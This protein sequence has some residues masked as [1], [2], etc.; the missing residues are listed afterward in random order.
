MNVRI[1]QRLQGGPWWI[2][3]ERKDGKYV[4]QSLNTKDYSEAEKKG[5]AIALGLAQGHAVVGDD[6]TV[7]HLI[8]KF[9]GQPH[10]LRPS[11]RKRLE[12]VLKNVASRIGA[13]TV[14]DPGFRAAV[15]AYRAMRVN[16]GVS[17]RTANYEVQA[18][19]QVII[20]ALDLYPGM[21][22]SLAGLK[23]LKHSRRESR[24]LDSD[25][26]RKVLALLKTPED[27]LRVGLFLYT[28]MRRAEA[29]HLWWRQVNLA[30]RVICIESHE[31]FIP[32]NGEARLVPICDALYNILVKAPRRSDYVLTT[33]KGRPF[34]ADGGNGMLR[35]M[36]KLYVRA[37]IPVTKGMG[38]HT[39][40]H[41]Y[42]SHLARQNVRAELRAKLVGHRV[43]AMQN[44]YT[45][46]T[47]EDALAAG[48][49]FKYA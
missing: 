30:K 11:S 6:A 34:H 17:V 36:K 41:T 26:V 39:L 15:K 24:S 2:A 13:L 27:E 18:L 19:H 3:Y 32:K 44:I 31:G 38:L 5:Y 20:W 22:D 35:W 28:G 48:R 1:Y 49:E 16:N 29:I 33:R 45:H 21:A 40:R 10:T 12:G 25:E 43:L 23:Q 46:T 7:S 9:L 37:K 47:Q 14:T 8:Q 42:C 4:R